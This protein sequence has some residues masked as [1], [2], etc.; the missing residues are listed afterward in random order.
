MEISETTI[1]AHNLG[2]RAVKILFLIRSVNQS[3]LKEK[4][5]LEYLQDEGSMMSELCAVA[6]QAM[7]QEYEAKSVSLEIYS[8]ALEKV[9]SF[10]KEWQTV[11]PYVRQEAQNHVQMIF[12]LI[13]IAEEKESEENQNGN[14][15]SINIGKRMLA[16]FLEEKSP[17]QIKEI[18]E[19]IRQPQGLLNR[20]KAL[21]VS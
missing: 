9:Q 1:H 17:D 3:L 13:Q 14:I 6:L 12:N 19:A 18:E 8:S 16:T 5:F 11:S 10:Q 2:K 15:H 4:S 21:I 20:L 7:R